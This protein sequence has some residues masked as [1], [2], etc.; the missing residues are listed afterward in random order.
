MN[1]RI[2]FITVYQITM[3]FMCFTYIYIYEIYTLFPVQLHSNLAVV[4]VSYMYY[5]QHNYLFIVDWM[6]LLQCYL[7]DYLNV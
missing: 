2:H 5:F 3:W 4:C 1:G 7:N 6:C